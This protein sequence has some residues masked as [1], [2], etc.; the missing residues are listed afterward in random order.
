MSKVKKTHRV[1]RFGAVRVY[2]ITAL[3]E[4]E[5]TDQNH[6]PFI[7]HRI[8]RKRDAETLRE[9]AALRRYLMSD[10]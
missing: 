8:M 9:L 3:G 6:G 4:Q 10:R 5:V 7:S 1:D 2:V